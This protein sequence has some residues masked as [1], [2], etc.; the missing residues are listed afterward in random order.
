MARWRIGF[1]LL[2]VTCLFALGG[3]GGGNSGPAAVSTT[4]TTGRLEVTNAVP[5]SISVDVAID[6]KTILI[7]VPYTAVSGYLSL[8]PGAHTVKLTVNTSG[9]VQANPPTLTASITTQVGVD[10]TL[11]ASGEV[12][13]NSL[14]T[15][16]VNDNNSP[17][18]VGTSRLR[19]AD[20][21]PNAGAVDIYV[22]APGVDI[23]NVA[24]TYARVT[25]KAVSGYFSVTSGAREV[26][27]TVAGS[28][29]PVADSSQLTVAAGQT[30][31]VYLFGDPSIGKPYQSLLPGTLETSRVRLVNYDAQDSL[32]VYLGN[33]QLATSVAYSAAT[34][35]VPVPSG[36]DFV[37]I[38]D[39]QSTT[40]IIE[41]TQTLLPSTDYS[42]FIASGNTGGAVSAFSVDNNSPAPTGMVRLRVFDAGNLTNP[43]RTGTT[44]LGPTVIV[45][46]NSNTVLATIPTS[47]GT[48]SGYAT[49]PVANGVN[50]SATVPGESD[51]FPQHQVTL[52]VY[53]AIAASVAAGHTY[54]FVLNGTVTV[55]TASA[56]FTELSGGNEITN[57]VTYDVPPPPGGISTLR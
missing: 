12:G 20:E 6:G 40:P 51:S 39:F 31:T 23:T 21:A 17:T 29:T 4:V 9:S 46:D 2:I 19:I 36:S 34:P 14:T 56:T 8:A 11:I 48:V 43:T 22:T 28:K 5:D 49:V 13:A 38:N 42:Y 18:S 27:F 7:G 25:Y 32:D 3:C 35:Y 24:P 52:S 15:T 41:G 50:L 57:T 33:S 44:L 26:R 54:S 30:G 45:T 16:L 37:S 10:Q 53:G 1:A 55:A 47:F